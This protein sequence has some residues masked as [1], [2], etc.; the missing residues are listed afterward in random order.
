MRKYIF[1]LIG[2][3]VI[4]STDI[5]A[6]RRRRGRRR[7]KKKTKPVLRVEKWKKE[8]KLLSFEIRPLEISYNYFSMGDYNKF[9][10]EEEK[11]DTFFKEPWPSIHNAVELINLEGLC[12]YKEMIG[13]GIGF[14]G[15]GVPGAEYDA[16]RQMIEG[17][18]TFDFR[19]EYWFYPNIISFLFTS[20][21][22]LPITVPKLRVIVGLGLGIYKAS[23]Y[24]GAEYT[25]TTRWQGLDVLKSKY[26]RWIDDGLNGT[27][28]GFHI[29]GRSEFLLLRWLSAYIN[30]GMRRAKICPL[31]GKVKIWKYDRG[32]ID[33]TYTEDGRLWVIEDEDDYYFGPAPDSEKD[34]D[35]RD[36]SVDYSGFKIG[37]GILFRF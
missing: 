29:I 21:Y 20:Y 4:A 13:I 15:V 28:I 26:D 12:F 31:K 10:K 19:K 11:S 24:G 9:A 23:V 30:I 5:E 7:R 17:T 22:V 27:G 14:R 32:I 34:K 33:T 25:V 2:L 8:P 18:D 35:W 36:G 16:R 6:Y 1:I 37:A 3:L